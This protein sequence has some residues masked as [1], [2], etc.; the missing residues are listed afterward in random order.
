M[1]SCHNCHSTG[2]TLQSLT[3]Q[4]ISEAGRVIRE[5]RRVEVNKMAAVVNISISSDNQII[6]GVLQLHEIPTRWTPNQLALELKK[7]RVLHF[8]IFTFGCS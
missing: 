6:H 2:P 7:R 4:A 8:Y 3:P 5:Y 1:M